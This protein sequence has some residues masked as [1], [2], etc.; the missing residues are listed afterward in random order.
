MRLHQVQAL[1]PEKTY[2]FGYH[3]HG[4]I[5]MGAAVCFAT[6]ACGFE[7]KFPGIDIRVLT[8]RYVW[9]PLSVVA[10]RAPS[11]SFLVPTPH[12]AAR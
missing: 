1:D 10:P 11:S 3:P 2:V 7:E 4:I 5:S 8:L 9:A 12:R 6:N